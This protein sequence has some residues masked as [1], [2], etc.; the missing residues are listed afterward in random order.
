MPRFF[1]VPKH[2]CQN[3]KELT[4]EGH[5]SGDKLGQQQFL[6]TEDTAKPKLWTETGT[7]EAAQERLTMHLVGG[8]GLLLCVQR[9]KRSNRQCSLLERVSP[10]TGDQNPAEATPT[11]YSQSPRPPCHTP[12]PKMRT[13]ARAAA[14][15]PSCSSSATAAWIAEGADTC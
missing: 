2:L 8:R 14:S 1:T 13:F 7:A 10:A 12:H 3:S 4:N 5:Q 11:P 9:G 15:H 6:L